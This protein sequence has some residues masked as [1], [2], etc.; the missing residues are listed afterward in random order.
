M[1]RIWKIAGAAF[2]SCLEDLRR[3][4]C[5]PLGWSTGWYSIASTNLT[6]SY[7]DRLFNEQ[8]N[9]VVKQPGA[10]IRCE[11]RLHTSPRAKHLQDCSCKSVQFLFVDVRLH[12]ISIRAQPSVE[13]G[14]DVLSLSPSTIKLLVAQAVTLATVS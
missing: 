14:Q 7:V 10:D 3:V 5:L 6:K 13:Q 1:I 8:V 2:R 11:P 12:I 9:T 4:E